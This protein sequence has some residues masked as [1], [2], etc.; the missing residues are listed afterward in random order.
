MELIFLVNLSYLTL[1]TKNLH[2]FTQQMDYLSYQATP[3]VRLDHPLFEI[4]KVRVFI[5]RE[6]LNHP[7]VSG[8]K[9]WKLKYNLEEARK[10]A[11]NTVLT[12]GGAYS[13][14]IYAT[15]AAAGLLGFSS[16]GIIR[17]EQYL[18]LNNTL[19]F[20]ASNGMI[21][22]Y[23]SRFDY[24][25]KDDPLFLVRLKETFGEFYL[26]PEGGTNTQAIRG[27]EEFTRE[28]ASF[29]FDHVF[30]PVGT[31]GTISGIISGLNGQRSVVGV[32][33][34]KNGSFLE[35]D[36]IRLT[37]DHAGR[38]FQNWSL[39]TEYDHGGYAKST[40]A[41]RHFISD[42]RRLY[43][44]PLDHVYTGKLLFAVFEEV[45]KG[46]FKPGAT[47]LVIHTGGQQGST[48]NQMRGLKAL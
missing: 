15:A 35:N 25:R 34:L 22:S 40:P 10:Q 19:R 4:K 20:A 33:V 13:N 16:I 39:L 24:R 44:I 18:P 28:F 21:L 38:S 30:V 29:H 45:R 36:I 48:E 27:V 41:L 46:A 11:L 7:L 42:I 14:H 5:K 9:W 47:L 37:T 26:V 32:S 6:D 12:F 17:G 31:A 8:N 1:M 43:G 23:L 2:Y 3:I